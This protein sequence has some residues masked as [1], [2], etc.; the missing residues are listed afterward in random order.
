M[1]GLNGPPARYYAEIP[2]N[3][4]IRGAGRLGP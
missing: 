1:G 4:A 3:P 2:E